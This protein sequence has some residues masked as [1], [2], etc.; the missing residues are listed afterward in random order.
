MVPPDDSVL[1]N[2]LKI[3]E[4]LD[5]DLP[6]DKSL[7]SKEVLKVD[8]GGGWTTFYKALMFKRSAEIPEEILTPDVINSIGP[9]GLSPLHLAVGWANPEL[10]QFLVSKGAN[11]HLKASVTFGA[12]ITPLE[13]A[14][15]NKKEEK[16]LIREI[17]EK[18]QKDTITRKAI[19]RFEANPEP[20]I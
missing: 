7:W 18:S 2:A 20:E 16:S 1:I 8:I 9:D 12:E 14:S 3:K 15:S 11:I 4:C 17:L 6:I 19:K 10:V 5:K 13:M